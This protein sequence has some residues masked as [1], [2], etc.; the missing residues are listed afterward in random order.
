MNVIRCI[1]STLV[2]CAI[3]VVHQCDSQCVLAEQETTSRIE[4]GL[5]TRMTVADPGFGRGGGGGH[6]GRCGYRL[7]RVVGGAAPGRV[8]EGGKALQF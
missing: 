4:R 5:V 8:R 2:G 3:S 7:G 1:T 6:N